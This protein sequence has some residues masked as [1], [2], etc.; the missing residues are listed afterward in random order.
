MWCDKAHNAPSSVIHSIATVINY[1]AYWGLD[2]S[3]V[4]YIAHIVL[5]RWVQNR[6]NTNMPSCIISWDS[7]PSEYYGKIWEEKDKYNN[8]VKHSRK[9]VKGMILTKGDKGVMTTYDAQR[10]ENEAR[11]NYEHNDVYFAQI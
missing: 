4:S 1:D 8:R 3:K 9:W 5:M 6:E 11:G 7:C 10:D 2:I